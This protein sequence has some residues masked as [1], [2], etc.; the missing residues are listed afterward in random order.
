[1]KS[2][3]LRVYFPLPSTATEV[4]HMTNVPDCSNSIL[5]DISYPTSLVTLSSNLEIPLDKSPYSNNSKYGSYKPISWTIETML[6]LLHTT[7]DGRYILADSVKNSGNLS[8]NSKNLLTHLLINHLLQDQHKGN[9]LFFRKIAELIVEVFPKEQKSVYFIPSKTEGSHQTHAKGNLI[10]RW[11]NVAR[12]LKFVGAISYDRVKPSK[13]VNTIS[14]YI[15]F[16]DEVL[17]VKKWLISDGL[18]FNLC[19]IGDKWEF[20]FNLRKNDKFDLTSLSDVFK[21]W[22]IFQGPNSYELVLGNN[23]LSRCRN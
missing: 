7:N 23:C 5:Q 21:A 6:N 20:T 17:E 16:S 14:Q 19:D 11:K 1:M 8:D 9:D 18:N 3:V 2:D 22:P 4:L 10:E 13:T 15:H 12:R